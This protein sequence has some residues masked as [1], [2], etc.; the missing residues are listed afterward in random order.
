[1]T[2]EL[3]SKITMWRAKAADGTITLE[4]MKEAVA[5][6]REGRRTAAVSPERARTAKA[7]AAIPNADD[8]LAELGI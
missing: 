6:L 5:A 7:K 2:P 3:Q 4:E 1:M 8:M